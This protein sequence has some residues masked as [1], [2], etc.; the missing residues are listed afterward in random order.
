M[1]YCSSV[2]HHCIIMCSFF[3]RASF[4]PSLVV[5]ESL[6]GHT[7]VQN[8]KHHLSTSIAFVSVCRHRPSAREATPSIGD[9]LN[10]TTT[11]KIGTQCG[12]YG[13]W[14][15]HNHQQQAAGRLPNGPP[16][17]RMKNNLSLQKNTSKCMTLAGQPIGQPKQCALPSQALKRQCSGA[18]H[19]HKCTGEEALGSSAQLTTG[20]IG[21]D[22]VMKTPE[23]ISP[24]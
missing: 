20:D 21:C 22:K 2:I 6:L 5:Y 15:R 8:N 3:C 23:E 18:L 24:C 16:K 11:E 7:L 19:H 1:F 12:A 9:S 17:S 10:P 14:Q 13:W 4:L